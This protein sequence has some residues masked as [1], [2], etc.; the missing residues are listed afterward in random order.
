MSDNDKLEPWG[1]GGSGEFR[2]SRDESGE[3]GEDMSDRCEWTRGGGSTGSKHGAFAALRSMV[4]DVTILFGR[5]GDS[6]G[7]KYG[8]FDAFQSTFDRNCG[9][10]TDRGEPTEIMRAC[11][12]VRV[13]ASAIHGALDAAVPT[14][15]VALPGRPLEPGLGLSDDVPW[16]E[17]AGDDAS[18]GV[19]GMLGV[20]GTE[21]ELW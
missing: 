1:S 19:V 2:P 18:R 20:C 10:A 16:R 5:G 11:L 4:D 7:L 13:A 14:D 9:E 6:G 17:N 15:D 21:L 8:A 3:I 12:L